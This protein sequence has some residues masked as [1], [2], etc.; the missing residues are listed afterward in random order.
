MSYIRTCCVS[1]AITAGYD[2]TRCSSADNIVDLRPY[3]LKYLVLELLL[4]APV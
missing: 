1:A 4:A 2:R 3:A